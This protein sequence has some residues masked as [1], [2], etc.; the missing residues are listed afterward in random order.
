MQLS[1]DEVGVG[2]IRVHQTQWISRASFEFHLAGILG[3]RPRNADSSQLEMHRLRFGAET[4]GGQLSLEV[5]GEKETLALQIA[6]A[7]F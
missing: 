4:Q 6:L 3:S 5:A 7:P 1:R 2:R